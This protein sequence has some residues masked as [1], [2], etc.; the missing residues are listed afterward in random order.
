[1][2]I[3]TRLPLVWGALGVLVPALAAAEVEVEGSR[4]AALRWQAASGAVVGYYVVVSRN[5]EP[6]WV[7]SVSLDTEE[8][9]TGRYG[10]S[11]SVQVAA[12]G[13]DG[14]AGP[15]SPP[16]ATL[17]FTRHGS[18]GGG[19]GDSGDGGDPG[20]DPAPDPD[21]VPEP[22]DPTPFDRDGD[23]FSD[24]VVRAGDA[25]TLWS[26]QGE[27]VTTSLPLP[28]VP[29]GAVLAG[30]GD[31]DGNGVADALWENEATGELTLWL[32]QGGVVIGNQVL[33]RGSL[34]EAEAWRVGST[35]R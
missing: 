33:D 10:D 26:V 21:P 11:V 6:G 9:V 34:A 16:S 19:S 5:G 1:M 22:G 31:Y 20:G 28:V 13:I 17:R 3:R 15:L 27:L 23:G 14:A 32:L 7:E 30:S 12:F 8:T 24:L 2:D 29:G 25:L 35:L 4:R 18:G